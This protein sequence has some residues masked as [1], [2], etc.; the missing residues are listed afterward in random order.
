MVGRSARPSEEIRAPA[1]LEHR[2][3]RLLEQEVRDVLRA[4]RECVQDG[5]GRRDNVHRVTAVG[6]SLDADDIATLRAG[7]PKGDLRII[8]R[9][10]AYRPGWDEVATCAGR[11]PTRRVEAQAARDAARAVPDVQ[12]AF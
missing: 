7:R 3:A 1:V 6:E 10:G 2:A 12:A 9:P 5:P 4:A 11:G 8:G